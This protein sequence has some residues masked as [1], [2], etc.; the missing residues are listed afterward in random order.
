MVFGCARQLPQKRDVLFSDA[1]P[2]DDL[3]PLS[4]L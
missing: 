4:S 2:G 1:A 3:N